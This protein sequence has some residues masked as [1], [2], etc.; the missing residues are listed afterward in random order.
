M[1]TICVTSF[2]KLQKYIPYFIYNA[3]THLCEASGKQVIQRCCGEI[4]IYTQ[5]DSQGSYIHYPPKNSRFLSN[6]R[7]FNVLIKCFYN[8]TVTFT[9]NT[10]YVYTTGKTQQLNTYKYQLKP[11]SNSTYFASRET[12]HYGTVVNNSG[13]TL[14]S[15][16]LS[17]IKAN[18]YISVME[19][20][21][22]VT[23]KSSS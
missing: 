7:Q 6:L 3:P 5:Y 22:A 11:N 1:S 20:P 16:K 21:A 23:H 19:K 10:Q 8:P 12:A 15:Q 17:K 4:Y 18:Y 2:P 14:K 13:Q 9:G